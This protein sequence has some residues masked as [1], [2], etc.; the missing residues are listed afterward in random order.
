MLYKLT[1][2]R[3]MALNLTINIVKLVCSHSATLGAKGLNTTWNFLFWPWKPLRMYFRVSK[4]NLKCLLKVYLKWSVTAITLSRPRFSKILLILGT[5]IFKHH[6]VPQII[7]SD[8]IW[9]H[10]WKAETLLFHFVKNFAN[11]IRSAAKTTS[12]PRRAPDNGGF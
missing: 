7:E 8:K 6:F 4:R 12:W 9:I 11:N 2:S 3:L 5:K 10:R 1:F